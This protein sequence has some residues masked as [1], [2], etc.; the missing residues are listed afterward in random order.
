MKNNK[1]K[2]SFEIEPS[3]E[4]ITLGYNNFD[5]LLKEKVKWLG[6]CYGKISKLKIKKR[7]N[8]LNRW[9]DN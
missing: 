6:C 1:Y 3:R 9:I 7:N 4:K 8:M 2:V 5:M